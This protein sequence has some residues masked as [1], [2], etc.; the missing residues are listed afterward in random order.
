MANSI[1]ASWAAWWHARPRLMVLLVI[2]CSDGI[3]PVA[4]GQITLTELSATPLPAYF[5]PAYGALARDSTLVL[6]ASDTSVIF[7]ERGGRL[8]QL[9]KRLSV[10]AIACAFLPADSLVEVIEESPP[11]IVQVNMRDDIV[12]STN[13][14]LEGRPVGALRTDDGWYVASMRIGADRPL[15]LLG[16]FDSETG[17]P[18]WSRELPQFS[19]TPATPRVGITESDNGVVISQ[20]RSPFL[21]LTVSRSGAVV[22]VWPG[23]K[24]WRHLSG[25]SVI[26][27]SVWVASAAIPVSGGFV[28]SFADLRS[29]RR[30][31]VR[32]GQDGASLDWRIMNVPFGF[33]AANPRAG[34]LASIRYAGTRE[35]VRYAVQNRH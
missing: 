21:V 31:L 11:R 18:M 1:C 25:D 3:P 2:V 28:R 26:L 9:G 20:D 17:R 32:Y 14:K 15:L 6:G 34:M 12:R 30:L 35:A 8:L 29:D 22:R 19:V 7:V 10:R 4:E 5:N 16:L 24:S 27:D 13:L 23:E 33:L